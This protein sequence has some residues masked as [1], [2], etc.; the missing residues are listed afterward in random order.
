M[1]NC[2]PN[3]LDLH[4]QPTSHFD[5]YNVDARLFKHSRGQIKI[6]HNQMVLNQ[7]RLINDSND[8]EQQQIIWPLNGIRR[9]GHYKDIFLFESGRKCST[10]EGLFA[11]KCNKAKRL[12]NRLHKAIHQS[13]LYNLQPNQNQPTSVSNRRE[14]F[15][16]S[17]QAD[18]ITSLNTNSK[19]LENTLTSVS[20]ENNTNNDSK[21]FSLNEIPETPKLED[22]QNK[23]TTSPYY[24]NDLKS[25]VKLPASL[26]F[27]NTEN[28]KIT[29]KNPLQSD[30]VNSEL[31]DPS[32]LFLAKKINSEKLSHHSNLNCNNNELEHNTTSQ[33]Q[34]N[35]KKNYEKLKD[36]ITSSSSSSKLIYV[37]PDFSERSNKHEIDNSDKKI[38]SYKSGTNCVPTAQANE[39]KLNKEFDYITDYVTID[40]KKTHVIK[41]TTLPIK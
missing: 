17:D 33:Y 16:F 18:S 31:I 36:L 26:S 5:V 13:V 12:S 37:T 3:L 38:Q 7:K 15:N 9:Y 24:V 4:Q 10:G 35:K 32:L 14:V 29:S 2:S 21:Q 22:T 41:A 30:Y 6:T 8:F 39:S 28:G 34:Q 27:V 20:T 40:A 23:T 19:N 25:I 1:G 11:F